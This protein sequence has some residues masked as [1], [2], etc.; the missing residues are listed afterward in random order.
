MPQR[1]TS[2][3]L[4]SA[5]LCLLLASGQA[6][7]QC[8]G[9]WT[10]GAGGPSPRQNHGMVYDSA[11]EVVVLFGGYRGGVGFNNETWEYDGTSW[12]QISITGA[13]PIA[14]GNLGIAYD[15]ARQKTVLFGGAITGGA[16]VG[17]TWEYDGAAHT[18][19]EVFPANVPTS[20]FNHAM[21]FDSTRNRVVMFGGFGATRY[22]DTWSYDGST[23]TQLSTTGCTPR[24][25]HSMTYDSARDR[26]VL[27]GGFNGA[28]LADTWEWSGSSW[29][30][31]ATTGP[32]GRQYLAIDYDSRRG[33]TVLFA[34]QSGACSDCRESD[35]WSYSNNTWTLTGAT[36]TGPGRRDQHCMV[37]DA[38]RDR[39]VVFGGYAGGAN[40]LTDTWNWTPGPD[41]EIDS[42]PTSQSASL[43]GSAQFT[44]IGGETGPYDYQW[45][46]DGVPLSD[47]GGVS[48][49]TSDTLTINP[50]GTQHVGAYAVILSNGCDELQSDQVT[51]TI[52]CAADFNGDNQVDF[53]D[54]LDFAQAFDTE[55]PSADFNGDDQVDFFDYLDFVQA[56]SAGC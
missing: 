21:V 31:T 46:F 53:F 13:A 56:F 30:Q 20:R 5:S 36:G 27:F 25:G 3:L 50:V 41:V 15:S 28:R 19:T 18:W 47:G 12:T 32:I 17:D 35:T 14:R 6:A 7:A 49:S 26:V 45:T 40:V 42:Q 11:R 39:F 52:G 16:A 38:S 23:W 4:G 24:N 8:V 51:L 29:A 10:Q 34:G 1:A 9:F 55:D 54:Y 48:G 37:Y 33:A 43:G 44:V 2:I 22:G